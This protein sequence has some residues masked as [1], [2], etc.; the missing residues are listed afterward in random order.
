MSKYYGLLTQATG[1][2]ADAKAANFQAGS[3]GGMTALTAALAGADSLISAGGLDGVQVSSY[4]KYVLDNDQLGALRRH[5]RDD[6]IDR[7]DALMDDILEV[8]IGGHFLG[9]K[10]TR[11][12]S[13]TEVWRSGRLSAR[14]VR[15]VRR[16]AA[17]T[18]GRRRARDIPREARRCRRS[19]RTPTG[20]STRSSAGWADTGVSLAGRRRTC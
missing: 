13:R 2:S 14:D 20:T 17:R 1:M 10:S 6:A 16:A 19:P 11:A 7:D 9:R 12:F 5:L 18:R 15:G 4:A 3:E 8:G